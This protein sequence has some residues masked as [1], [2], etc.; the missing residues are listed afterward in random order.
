M[1]GCKTIEEKSMYDFLAD[2]DEYFCEKYANY[3]KLCVL[4]GYKMPLMQASR[5]DEYGR[6]YAYT[7]PA[8]TMRLATQEK[9]AELL[10]ELKTRLT[11]VTFSFSFKTLSWVEKLKNKHSKFGFAKNFAAMLQKYGLSEETAGETLTLSKEI[12]QGICKGNY[13]PTKNLLFSLALT[14]QMSLSDA[15]A[16]LS[17]AG[18]DFD[19]AIPKDVVMSYL[20]HN[21]VFNAGMVEAALAEY[22]V[23]NLFIAN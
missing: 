8:N 19:Y 11:D 17:L 16:L 6:T 9:K 10:V 7:L 21:K 15:T 14:A 13:L 12:W 22:N 18:Y 23:R 3:D 20:L 4:P 1:N 5:I 2:L